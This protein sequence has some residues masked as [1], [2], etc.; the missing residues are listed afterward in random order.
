M[1]A[2]WNSAGCGG[3][4]GPY[5]DGGRSY[6]F[7]ACFTDGNVVMRVLENVPFED[8]LVAFVARAWDRDVLT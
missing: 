7:S 8:N 2:G 5:L 4:V 3:E 6:F 1:L